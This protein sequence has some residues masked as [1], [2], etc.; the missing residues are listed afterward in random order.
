M[1]KR[2][3]IANSQIWDIDNSLVNFSDMQRPKYPWP[4]GFRE[5]VKVRLRVIL[6]A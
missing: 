4:S 6:V 2:M 3:E 1:K 5:T